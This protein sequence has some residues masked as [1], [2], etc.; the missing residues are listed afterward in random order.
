MV[1]AWVLTIP[2]AAA[3][4]FLMFWLTQLPT[5]FAWVAV[6]IVVIAFTLWVIKAMRSTIHASDVEAEIPSEAE[7]SV[8]DDD[9]TPHL[10]GGGPVQ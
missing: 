7:L 2:F 5:V 6:G 8:L 9:P 4:S 10:K 3:I 1:L